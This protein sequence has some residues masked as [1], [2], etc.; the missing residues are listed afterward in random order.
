MRRYLP[1]LALLTGCLLG[2]QDDGDDHGDVMDG[3]PDSTV[4]TPADMPDARVR[5]ALKLNHS[6]A[7][8]AWKSYHLSMERPYRGYEFE[9]PPLGEQIRERGWRHFD[10]DIEFNPSGNGVFPCYNNGFDDYVSHCDGDVLDCLLP[11]GQW[12]SAHPRHAPIVILFQQ[13]QSMMPDIRGA[14][15]FLERDLMLMVGGEE[16]IHRIYT[17]ADALADHPGLT[18]REML[19]EHDWPDLNAARGKFIFVLNDDL[20]R[21]ANRDWPGW[22]GTELRGLMWNYADGLSEAEL[23]ADDAAFAMLP[24][25]ET[26]DDELHARELV[27]RGYIVRA[28]A[29]SAVPY[30]RAVRAGV[31]LISSK[32]PDDLYPPLPDDPEN[33]G[34]IGWPAACNPITAPPECQSADI[35]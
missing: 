16:Q 29:H 4:S 35:E 17:P 1:A 25:L 21:A 3:G 14:L 15:D 27:E 30:A 8:G 31:H 34:D 5:P 26:A 6:Q 12:S 9:H 18:L 23:A 7:R 10:F 2:C 28:P 11:L 13:V 32:W 33:P 20:A 24:Q 22:A 19:T